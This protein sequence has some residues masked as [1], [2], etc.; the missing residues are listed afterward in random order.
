MKNGFL[1][2]SLILMLFFSSLSLT[3]IGEEDKSDTWYVDDD[4]GADFTCVQDA[5][6][7]ASPVDTIFV[8]SGL[9]VENIVVNKTLKLIGED[10][11]TTVLDGNYTED[12]LFI[13]ENADYVEITDFTF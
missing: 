6:D 5:V 7:A 12:T 4:G 10:K 11:N 8:Y 13:T 1:S 2:I 9:Y 3:S